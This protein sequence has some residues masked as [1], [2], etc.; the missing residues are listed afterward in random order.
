LNFIG[1]HKHARSR[2]AGE[3]ET[4]VTQYV[5]A[6]FLYKSRR[7]KAGCDPGVIKMSDKSYLIL[8]FG[9]LKEGDSVSWDVKRLMLTGGKLEKNGFGLSRNMK[10]VDD[11]ER[12]SDTWSKLAE[13]RKPFDKKIAI[14]DEAT[15]IS[16]VYRD[17]TDKP[18]SDHAVLY[19][20]FH[21][22]RGVIEQGEMEAELDRFLKSIAVY[23]K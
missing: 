21:L 8:G 12:Y 9:F 15:G 5:D 14:K 11:N 23:E 17:P 7:F 1:A 4:G 22:K 2:I 19:D 20:V 13:G 3:T 6:S 10:P 18:G 16:T